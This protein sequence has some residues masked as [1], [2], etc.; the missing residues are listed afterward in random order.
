MVWGDIYLAVTLV[1]AA[2]V[3]N[4]FRPPRFHLFL[5]PSFF[6]GWYT[7]EM[8]VWHIVWQ[9]VVT[10]AVIPTGAFGSWPGLVGLG[11]AGASWIGL[12]V[13]A[14]VGHRAGQVFDRVEDATA[15]LRADGPR[16]DGVP[17][18]PA[19]GAD[20]MWRFPRLAYPLPRP[21]RSVTVVRNIDYVGD[22]LH[23]QRLDIIRRRRDP[24]TA[25]PVLVYIHGGAWVVGDKREQ[26]LPLLYEL[27]RRGWVTVTINYRLS[28]RA[29]WP[30]HIVDCKR[31]LAWVRANIAGYGGDPRF[32][33]V[34]GGSA[35]GHLCSLLAL[36]AGDPAFQPGFED[37]S[38]VVDACVAFY[39]VFDMTAARGSAHYDR[40][41]MT[42]LE[43][44]V[45]KTTADRDPGVFEAASP[46]CRVHDGAPPFF[47]IHGTHDTLVPVAEAR[48]FVTALR[49]VSGAPVLYAELPFTQ[50]AFDVL[51]SVRSA[52]A[53][54]AVVRF[55]EGVRLGPPERAGPEAAPGSPA[56][57][58]RAPDQATAGFLT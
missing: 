15:L 54:A 16:G 20:T 1:G 55:L 5:V 43:R 33:A 7:G 29:T 10:A 48:R 58:G 53:V 27:A 36:T 14:A 13:L 31:A 40:G 9:V 6:A 46:L 37:A 44:R 3:L 11:V 4:A 30:D 32:L 26:G 25:A 2:L 19:T 39:G 8:P 18:L 45:F 51:P 35:G 34:S 56:G 50:H 12:A 23:T 24:P 42:L 47:V 17:A 41:L 52:H 22:G 49:S 21:T 57:E 28:P 38:T